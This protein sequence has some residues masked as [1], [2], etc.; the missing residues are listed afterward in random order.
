MN[1]K[2]NS[3]LFISFIVRNSEIEKRQEQLL[4]YVYLFHNY[5]HLLNTVR[6]LASRLV[7]VLILCVT[8]AQK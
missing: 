5:Y 8:K 7:R 6:I 1:K 4:D 3:R 2:L